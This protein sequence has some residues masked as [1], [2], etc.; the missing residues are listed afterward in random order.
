M[1]VSNEKQRSEE[2][3]FN[4]YNNNSGTTVAIKQQDYIVVASDTRHSSEMGI[5]SRTMS[6]VFVINDFVMSTTGFY[7]DSYEVFN[8]LKYH[9]KLYESYNLRK[10]SIHSA[11]HLL[12][13]I[14]YERRFFP[15]YS[16]IVLSGFG[17]EPFVYEYDPI[18]CYGSVNCNCT[19]SSESLIQP[20]LDS[21]ISK[22][23]WENC[24]ATSLTT[25]EAVK[26]VKMAFDSAAE[27]DVK[28]GDYLE[29]FVLKREGTVKE[30]FEL[31]K[32]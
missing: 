20:L 14:L 7:G 18:G 25:E 31:R 21:L 28:T 12:H 22:K 29:V 32:D 3:K 2:E 11:A 30:V 1:Q 27:R 24:E 13:N 15:Y 23:N 16:F 6:K 26:L 4:P 9:I 8:K 5:N 17:D 10:I 19:G